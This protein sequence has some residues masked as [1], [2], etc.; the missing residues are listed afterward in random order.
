MHA[1][2]ESIMVATA[3]DE[4]GSNDVDPRGMTNNT[5]GVARGSVLPGTIR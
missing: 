2:E 5:V 1:R 3:R 4:C